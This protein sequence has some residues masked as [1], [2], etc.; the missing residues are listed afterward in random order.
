MTE[1]GNYYTHATYEVQKETIS[2][3]I[4]YDG[5]VAWQFYARAKNVATGETKWIKLNRKDLDD[6]YVTITT[7]HLSK[8]WFFCAIGLTCLVVMGI[9]GFFIVVALILWL[10]E[11]D[12]STK[13]GV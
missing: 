4:P 11:N 12:E 8:Y 6:K 7:T 5:T 2:Q 10:F 3:N 13:K 1:D 9:A